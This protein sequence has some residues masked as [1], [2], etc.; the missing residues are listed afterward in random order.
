MTADLVLFP[1]VFAGTGCWIVESLRGR[2]SVLSPYLLGKE[3]GCWS[4]LHGLLGAESATC[5]LH[6]RHS[7]NPS[8]LGVFVTSAG[9]H[10]YM[11]G[12]PDWHTLFSRTAHGTR[13][14]SATSNP[15]PRCPLYF[16]LAPSQVVQSCI[17]PFPD[18][19]P[20]NLTAL[21]TWTSHRF[22]L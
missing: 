14:Q 10:P 9:P 21:C 22:D 18:C 19:P 16:M 15:P 11:R 3:A 7:C 20:L 4:E 1:L 13:T 12:R 6:K 17:P 5:T 2:V 8:H